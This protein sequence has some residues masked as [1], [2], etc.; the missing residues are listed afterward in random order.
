MDAEDRMGQ[1]ALHFAAQGNRPEVV[2]CLTKARAWVDAYD[3]NDDTALHVAI[4]LAPPGTTARP[5]MLLGAV[6]DMWTQSSICSWEVQRW[7]LP[8]IET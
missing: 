6:A 4:R 1:T 8:T 7:R 5:D 3:S 2:K